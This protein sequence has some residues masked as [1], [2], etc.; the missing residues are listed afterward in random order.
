MD[1]DNNDLQIP[2]YVPKSIGTYNERGQ[3]KTAAESGEVEELW[4]SSFL[5]FKG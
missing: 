3:Q 1:L 4:L 2:E 5:S